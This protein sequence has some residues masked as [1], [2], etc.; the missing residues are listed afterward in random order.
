MPELGT[1]GVAAPL[2]LGIFWGGVEVHFQILDRHFF[3]LMLTNMTGNA[4]LPMAATQ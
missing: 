4:Y 1:E 3:T 2:A